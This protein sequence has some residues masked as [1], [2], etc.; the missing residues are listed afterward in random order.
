MKVLFVSGNLCDGGAQ[1]VISIVA[2]RLAELG[3]QVYL[4]LYSRNEKEYPLYSKVKVFALGETF[5]EYRRLSIGKK[6]LKI[7]KYIKDISPDIAIGFLEGGYGLFLASLGMN[8]I[9]IASSR[10]DPTVLLRKKGMRAWLDKIWFKEADAVVVQTKQQM[11]HAR[12]AGW[13]QMEIIPNPISDKALIGGTHNYK[14]PCDK[15]IMVGRLAAQK[16]YKM[17]IEAMG[18]LKK[19]YPDLTL[20]IYGKGEEKKYLEEMID[21]K[22]LGKE[23]CIQ[24]WTQDVTGELKKHDIYLLCSDFEGMPNSL[25]EAMAAGLL[26]ISTD[27][28]TGPSDLIQDGVNGLLI[29]TGDAKALVASMRKIL[30]KSEIERKEMGEQAFY[31]IKNNFNEKVITEKWIQL[32]E[33]LIRKR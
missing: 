14:R 1:R 26:C 2:S 20:D 33:K 7:R 11:E 31:T 10:I 9:K 17:A 5:E 22:G 27:C 30:Q 19:E 15:I 8:V 6:I 29:P 25:M 24:G 16:N 21:E 18:I 13:K 32:F 4:L 3:Y 12:I 23:I 28:D